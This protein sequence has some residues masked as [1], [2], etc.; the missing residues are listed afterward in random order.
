MAVSEKEKQLLRTTLKDMVDLENRKEQVQQRKQGVERELRSYRAE[1]SDTLDAV[2]RSRVRYKG[3]LI[4]RVPKS[5]HRTPT[6]ALTYEA[7]ENVLGKEATEKVKA[8]VK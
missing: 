5:Q 2:G 6:L 4:S 7:I 3:L 8:E 1:L